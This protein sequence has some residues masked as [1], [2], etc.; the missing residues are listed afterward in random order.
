MPAGAAVTSFLF[1]G[2]AR[3]PTAKLLPHAEA[4]ETY[5]AIVR[6]LRDPA[7]LEF[8][9]YNL[10]RSSVFPVPA[11]GRQKIRLT[12][13]H[14]LP[15]VQGRVDYLL[16]RS[17]SLDVAAPWDV[18]V[19]IRSKSPISTTY[20]PSHEVT[21]KRHGPH[22][23]SVRIHDRAVRDPGPFR[24]SV[25]LQRKAVSATLFTY[26]DP[27][28]GGG[29]FLLLAGLPAHAPERKLSLKREVTIVIDRSGSMAGEKLDQVR[30]AALQTIEGLADGEAFNIIDYATTVSAM[31]AAPVIKSAE[32]T[33][34]ARAY[35][36][37]LRPLGGTNIHDAL[38]EA[39]RQPRTAKTLPLVLFLT[40]GLPTIGQVS[41]VAIR[42]VVAKGNPHKRRVFAFGVGHDVN[43]PLLDRI[44]ELSRAKP[45]YVH[46][47]EDVELKVASVVDQL[48]G[49]VLSSAMLETV[50]AAGQVVTDVVREPIPAQIPDLFG[51][52]QLVLLGQ[53]RG[54]G[55]I[56]F[57]L[58][59]DYLGESRSF[60]MSFDLAKA[61][62]RNSFVPRLWASRRIAFLID[63]IRQA[64][65]SMPGRTARRAGTSVLN[66]PKYKE[67][68]DEI[69]RLST[70]FGILS[71][72]TAFLATEGTDLSDWEKL[73]R[74]AALQLDS[75]VV[76]TRWGAS[77]VARAQNVENSKKQKALN[78]FNRYFDG[79][80]NTK[81]ISGVQQVNDRAL[82]CRGMT[83]IDGRIVAAK[84]SVKA[85]IV[86]RYGTPEFEA[87]LKR[88]IREGRQSLLAVTGDVVCRLDGKNVRIHYEW[89]KEKSKQGK[90]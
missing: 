54:D 56:H 60:Q 21:T 87:L 66:A 25:L 40:D 90:K 71:E 77:A 85:D 46:P 75:K 49:P 44:A 42:D 47:H 13:D 41:E 18:E 6:K 38:V 51:D 29:Y 4:R 59:G 83:W 1:D 12:Y 45:T 86:V 58:R 55:K 88:L 68:V 31:S 79:K 14:I 74:L 70:E 80:Q 7:L 43:A 3:E 34:R 32:T 11:G 57:R 24:L 23:V 37:S 76:Q 81:V 20:S 82:Y 89:N 67:L 17:E 64:G 8:A 48:Y 78:R 53:Y 5:D 26:P 10:I 22:H 50:D 35:L 62:T 72:Y 28:I 33:K 36:A 39:L 65:G 27:K 19:D 73:N 84:I 30:A 15:M 52:D 16:P 61:T 63:Q 69:L 2:P 9:G